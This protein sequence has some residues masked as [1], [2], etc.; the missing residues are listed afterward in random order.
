M[1]VERV[2]RNRIVNLTLEMPEDLLANP[3]NARRHPGPQRDVM[4]AT[5]DELGWVAPVIVNDLTGYVVDGHLRIEEAISE[6]AAVIPVVHVELSADE[7]RLAIAVL[8]PVGDLAVYDQDR[9]DD[10]IASVLTDNGPLNA[11]LAALSGEDVD[12]APIHVPGPP[13]G[14]TIVLVY[15]DDD[16]FSE[17]VGGLSLCPGTDAAD[18]V[19]RLVRSAI[20]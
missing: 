9:L 17:V 12:S 16:A 13:K 19:L 7:E 14:R 10:L 11:L 15:H 6:G 8:D 3:A 1:G 2:T 5:L 4:R 18:K 20:A